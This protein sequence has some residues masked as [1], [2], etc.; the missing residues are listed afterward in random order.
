MVIPEVSITYRDMW[1]EASDRAGAA[2]DLLREYQK[3][4]DALEPVEQGHV[5]HAARA[6]AV[7][8]G[9]ANLIAFCERNKALVKKLLAQEVE[10]EAAAVAAA[11]EQP[12]EAAE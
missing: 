11:I 10:A 12:A 3:Q 5:A 2:D 9:Q 8:A 4:E 1:A 6:K 7:A